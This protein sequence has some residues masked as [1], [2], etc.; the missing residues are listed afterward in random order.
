MTKERG[1][2]ICTPEEGKALFDRVCRHDLGISGDEFLR[3]YDAGE[4]VPDD[5]TPEG[6]TILHIVMLIPFAR[7]VPA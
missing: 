6:R 2:H 3:G 7:S 5:D 1:Y 4:I